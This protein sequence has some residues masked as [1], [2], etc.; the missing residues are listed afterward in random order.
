MLL[1]QGEGYDEVRLLPQLLVSELIETQLFPR[2]KSIS[3]CDI[4]ILRAEYQSLIEVHHLGHYRILFLIKIVLQVWH[5]L[6][7]F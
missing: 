7:I 1:H 3:E 4:K 2:P 6:F 5:L